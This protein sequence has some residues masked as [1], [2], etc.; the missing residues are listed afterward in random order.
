ML[1]DLYRLTGEP[2]RA[3]HTIREAQTALQQANFPGEAARCSARITLL[4]R[5]AKIL[6]GADGLSLNRPAEAI[7]VLQEA[8]DITEE[9]AR[10]DSEGSWSRLYFASLGREL[11]E[12]LRIRNP[13]KA[14]AIYDQALLRLQEIRDNPEARRGEAQILA[15]SA[16]ALRRLGRIDEANRRIEAAF[17]LLDSIQ[18]FRPRA[19][20]HGVRRTW[21]C[22]RW[23][24]TSPKRASRGAPRNSS[25]I[26]WKG[27]RLRIPTRRTIS[28][29][30]RRYRRYTALS[31]PRA[32]GPAWPHENPRFRPAAWNCGAVGSE[33][34]PGAGSLRARWSWRVFART[35]VQKSSREPAAD[36]A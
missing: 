4:W 14:L 3:L 27:S 20:P 32:A 35:P 13:Q 16:Y 28:A 25:R 22:A 9:W 2:E 36:S 8:F 26:C 18:D 7:A 21:C 34:S 30:R 33:N 1:A 6:G 15:G 31:L 12:L 23:P 11:G 17:R 29:T 24:T 5:E 10:D 19:L